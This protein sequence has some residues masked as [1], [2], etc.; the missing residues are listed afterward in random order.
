MEHDQTEYYTCCGYSRKSRWKEVT[1][2]RVEETITGNNPNMRKDMNTKTQELHMKRLK[3]IY[4]EIFSI[5]FQ[6]LLSV[7]L[8]N[9]GRMAFTVHR[10]Q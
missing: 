5:K 9:N 10:Y 4:T 2:R 7:N 1:K 6:N 8:E 3:E